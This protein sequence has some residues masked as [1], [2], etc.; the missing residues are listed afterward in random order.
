M[1]GELLN[2]V[3]RVEHVGGLEF[4]VWNRGERVERVEVG[5][6]CME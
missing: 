3:E 6:W 4:V 1:V 5:D 2:H